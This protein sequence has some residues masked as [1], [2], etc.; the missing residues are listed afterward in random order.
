MRNLLCVML[1]VLLVSLPMMVAVAEEAAL[2]DQGTTEVSDD[3]EEFDVPID[4]VYE[5]D[6]TEDTEEE[7][8]VEEAN[9]F[10]GEWLCENAAIFIDEE[11]GVFDV[12]IMWDTSDTEQDIWEYTCTL[13]AV[14]GALT[15]EGKKSH[16]TIGY[17]G[18][19]VSSVDIYAD[20]SATFTLEDNVLIWDDAKEH[21][22]QGM[23]FERSAE[24]EEL[25]EVEIEEVEEDEDE[26]TAD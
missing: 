26:E 25:I 17:E 18:E 6:G 2:T 9:P 11:D 7:D 20:G 4:I 24:D 8:M 19:D 5:D 21:V 16:E 3:G 12:F 23:R 1:V 10:F 13:D 14:T 15:G 22:A